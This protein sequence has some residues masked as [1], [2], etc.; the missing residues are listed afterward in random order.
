MSEIQIFISYARDDDGAPPDLPDAKGFVTFLHEQLNFEFKDLGQPRP[1]IWRDTRRIPNADQFEPLIEQAIAASSLLLVVLSKNWMARPFCRRELDSFAKRW[2]SGGELDLRQR[3]IVVGKRHVDPDKRPSLLQGQQGFAFYTLNDPEEVDLAHEFFARGRVRDDR[4]YECLSQLAEY[5]WRTAERIAVRKPPAGPGP[6]PVEVQPTESQPIVLTTGRTVYVGKPANDVRPAYDRLVK[7]LLGRGYAV[8]PEVGKEIPCDSSA[9]RFIDD[10]LAAAEVSVH[11]LGKKSGYSP[12]DEAPIAKLQLARAA[13]RMERPPNEAIG[14]RRIIWAPKSVED[15]APSAA[16]I[17][18]DPLAVL[19][20]F[21]H[22]LPSDKVEG[23]SLSKFVDFL[24][25]HLVR[26]APANRRPPEIKADTR[27]YLYHSPEDSDYVFDLAD[28]LQKRQVETVL[29][30]FEGSERE[31][32]SF[33]RQKLA[34]CDAVA[35]CWAAAPEVW[36]R[37]QSSELRDWHGLGRTKQF[38]YR[39]VV[40]GPPPGNRKKASKHLF[41]PSEIDVILD[42]TDKGRPLPELLDLL[43]PAVGP[44]AP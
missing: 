30:A 6:D 38:A 14:F 37:A 35:L 12:E 23:D 10:A 7:E 2:S 20:A 41:P 42:L 17:D 5:L 40:A 1:K 27:V 22:Q 31:V 18:R 25:Q 43:V 29:P 16:A 26:T 8:V 15:D 3:I 19:A 11:L 44:S 33:H 36:V 28:A 21:D 4:Y 13:L 32:K 9:V 39:S 24:I 34:E